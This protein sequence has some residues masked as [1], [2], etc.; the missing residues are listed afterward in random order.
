[1]IKIVIVMIII[2]MI[3][4]KVNVYKK[5]NINDINDSDNNNGKCS[6]DN[7]IKDN[8]NMVVKEKIMILLNIMLIDNNFGK[9]D[10]NDNITNLIDDN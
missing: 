2:V 5:D 3:N 9:K 6:S 8:K 10:N 1:M 4:E 7:N